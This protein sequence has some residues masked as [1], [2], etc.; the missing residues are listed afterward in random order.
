MATKKS[1]AV[2]GAGVSGLAAA[3][4]FQQ[5]G[6]TVSVFERSHDLGGVWEPSRSYPGIQTQSPK[7]LYRFTDKAMPEHYP[8]WPNGAQ[9]HGYLGTAMP[10]TMTCA[11]S[12]HSI[13][14]IA[15]M[16]PPRRW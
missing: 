8:E 16:D 12:S 7:D 1:V 2:I 4:V 3:K 9:V 14:E 10:T 15:A 11:A 13:L 6:H 5:T